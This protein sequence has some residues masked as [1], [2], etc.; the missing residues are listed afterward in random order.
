MMIVLLIITVLILIAIPNVT[1][2]SKSIDDKGCDAYVKMVEGQVQA[3]KMDKKEIPTITKLT[4]GGYLPESP[5]CPN[6]S[7]IA[8]DAEGKVS[9]S[10]GG[11]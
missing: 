2:H 7:A 6:G 4:E 8:I 9:A 3:Y 1:K 5:A 10:N 11:G